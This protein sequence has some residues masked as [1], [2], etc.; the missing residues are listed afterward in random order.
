MP[1]TH[2]IRS[3]AAAG[4]WFICVVWG[5]SQPQAGAATDGHTGPGRHGTGAQYQP[6]A[7]AAQGLSVPAQGRECDPAQPGLE[8]GYHVHPPGARICVPGGGDRLVLAKGDCHGGYRT[9]WTAGSVLTVWSRRYKL[10][11]RLRYSTPT[12]AASSPAKLLLA[13]LKAKESRS[14]W[15]GAVGH[16]IISLWN[17]SG[18]ASSTRT[19][20]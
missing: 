12:R 3:T 9:R 17:G 13:C 8:Y 16:W 1:N 15:T 7:P 14:A 2:G 19:C 4:W 11:A 5:T 20:I 6:S 10:M 18:A